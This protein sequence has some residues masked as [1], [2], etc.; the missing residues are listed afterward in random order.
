MDIHKPRPWHG[1]REFL[2]EVGTIVLGVLIAIGFEQAVE[3]LHHPDQARQ[4]VR[5]LR[6]ES[7]ENRRFIAYDLGVCQAGIGAAAASRHVDALAAPS[8]IAGCRPW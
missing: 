4:M 8:G 3:A 5:K 2:K 7:I 1:G 6:E